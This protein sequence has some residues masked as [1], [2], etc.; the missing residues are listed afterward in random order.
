MSW[1][2]GGASDKKLE[3]TMF[4]LK[5]CSKQMERLSRKAEKDQ[6]VQE[7]KI[8][9]ALQQGNIEGAKIYAE[10]AIRKKNESL[11]YLRMA[12]KVDAVQSRIQSAVAMKGLTRSMGQV[13]K[14]L[15]SALNSMD[16][17]KISAVME[18]SM[19]QA[20]TLSTPKDAVDQ[21]IQEVAD[22]AG[23]EV[24]DQLNDAQS[25]PSGSISVGERSQTQDDA[26]TRRLAKLRN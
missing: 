7:G 21:L 5:F 25:I 8:K 22:E 19:G 1:F 26:L 6:K 18:D 4:Q 20:T 3:D 10:N 9:K 16:L 24:M 11:S 15:E 12:S 17:Q 2:G 14:S 23:L 13:V